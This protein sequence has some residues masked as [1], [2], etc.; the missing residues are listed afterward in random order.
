MVIANEIEN[1]E[2]DRQDL[3]NDINTMA[4]VFPEQA[5]EGT[6]LATEAQPN[7]LTFAKRLLAG[8]NSCTKKDKNDGSIEEEDMTLL[9]LS[10]NSSSSS[11]L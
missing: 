1:C 9:L 10:S 11:L 6:E 2:G 8:T 4:E 5:K 7:A 3:T